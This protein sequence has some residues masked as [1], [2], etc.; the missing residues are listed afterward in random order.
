MTFSGGSDVREFSLKQ[1]AMNLHGFLLSFFVGTDY[2]S[3]NCC[4]YLRD[5]VTD[6]C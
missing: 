5:W 4:E 1:K 6:I 3:A 2:K